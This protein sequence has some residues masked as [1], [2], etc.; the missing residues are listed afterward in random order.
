M[1]HMGLQLPFHQARELEL[2]F[3]TLPKHDI[4]QH[5]TLGEVPGKLPIT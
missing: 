1:S 3:K 4:L 5:Y 2:S